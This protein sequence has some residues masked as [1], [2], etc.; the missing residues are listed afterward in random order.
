M[1][2]VLDS[3]VAITAV[4]GHGLC[5]SVIELC[6]EHHQIILCDNILTEIEKKLRKKIKVPSSVIS[7]FLNVL[8]SNAYIFTPIP[9]NKK[10]CRD[11]KDLMIFGLVDP[12]NV[13]VIITGDK[14]LLVLK[15]YGMAKIMTPRNFWELNKR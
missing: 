4:A 9:V 3:N 15:E 5:E 2:V 12:A 7:E 14:D 11:S 6:L 8:R 13:N 1:R 10:I